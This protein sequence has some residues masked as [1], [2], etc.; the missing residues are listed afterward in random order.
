MQAVIL[1]GGKG[2]RLKPYTIC[3]PKPLVPLGDHPVMEIIIRQLKRNGFDDIKIST[4][5]L[6][7]L[8]ESYFGNGEKWGVNIE[9]LRETSPL[10]T[11][12]FLTISTDYDENFLV[13]NGDI[14]T[15]L[16]F[17]GLF[18][19]HEKSGAMATVA[20]KNRK[21]QID[22]GVVKTDEKSYLL[23]YLEKPVYDFSVSMG[24]YVLSRSCRDL[25]ISEEAIGM[26]DLF[27]MIIKKGK[28]VFCFKSDCYWLDIG[29][30]DDYELAQDEFETY[31]KDFL[32]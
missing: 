20:V 24:V 1:A 4:G 10:S 27:L 16:D 15:S 8:I 14:L 18:N 3:F 6:S 22:F 19:A 5:H 30:I 17:K 9:Y 29:R 25:L 12:G 11:A 23:E 2:T 26:P 28:K 13:I 31:K 32:G 21:S 7:H